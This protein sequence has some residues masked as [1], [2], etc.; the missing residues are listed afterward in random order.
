MDLVRAK[1]LIVAKLIFPLV[2]VSDAGLLIRGVKS[3]LDGMPGAGLTS[4][5][6]P[7]GILLAIVV[8]GLGSGLFSDRLIRLPTLFVRLVLVYFG[9]G[10]FGEFVADFVYTTVALTVLALVGFPPII[11]WRPERSAPPAS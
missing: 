5:M 4:Q 11:S 7:I 6:Y 3:T 8:L 1:N 10:L 2:I 9:A